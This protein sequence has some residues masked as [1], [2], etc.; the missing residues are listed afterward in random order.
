MYRTRMVLDDISLS[1]H[2]GEAVA[3][4]GKNGCD[5]STLLRILSGVTRSTRGTVRIAPGTR[6]GLIPDRYEK[7]PLT[8]LQ[9]MSYTLSL[10]RLNISAAQ[11]YYRM[12]SLED[13]MDTPM[14]YLSR[15][16]LQKVAVV[17]ALVGQRDILFGG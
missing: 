13:M 17:Q 8:I 2:R 6:A 12:F 1:L 14:K 4:V 9:F 10:E 11:D 3:V 16:T 7:I 5:K 15:G